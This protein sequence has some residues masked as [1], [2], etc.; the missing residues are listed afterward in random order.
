MVA[1]ASV[2]Y[3]VA[4]AGSPIHLPQGDCVMKAMLREDVS[5]VSEVVGTILILGMTVVL[6][7]AIIIWVTSIP[8]PTSQTRLDIR[9]RMDPIYNGFGIEIGVNITLV[10][11]GGEALMPVPTVILVTSQRSPLPPRTD[12]VILHKYNPILAAPSG[13]LDGADTA[14]EIGERWAYKNFTLL[15]SDAIRI[16]IVDQEKNTVVWAGSMNA[17]Q[18]FRPPV[19]VDKWTDGIGTT[20]AVDPVL[21]NLGFYLFARVADPDNDLNPASVYANITAWYGS[22]TPCVLPLQMRDD[23]VFPDRAARDG[24]F[25]LGGNVCTNRPSPPLAWSGSIILLNA[26]DLKGHTTITR[27]V[28]TVAQPST[29]GGG[30]GGGTIPRQLWQ[31]I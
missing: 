10:H 28:L 9:S 21:A 24:V 29:G 12:R 30:G 18:G 3:S 23:G 6:F 22:G 31:Y 19:F 15:S 7:S 4:A 1:A 8:A 13:L 20:D 11:Q 17:V 16:A 14:W 26:T 5:G 25:S 27:L 2:L